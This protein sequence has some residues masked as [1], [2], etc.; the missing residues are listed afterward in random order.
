MRGTTSR[1]S[2]IEWYKSGGDILIFIS[3]WLLVALFHGQD[4]IIVK[5]S[6][7]YLF[8]IVPAVIL[9]ALRMRQTINALLFG[10]ARPIAAFGLIGLI[11]LIATGDW[12]AIPPLFLIAWVSGWACRDEI[13]IARRHL[14]LVAIGFFAAGAVTYFASY[15]LIDKS[16]PEYRWMSF[17]PSEVVAADSV[18]P[19]EKSGGKAAPTRILLPDQTRAGLNLNP[20]GV[21]P[22][23]TLQAFSSTWRVSATPAISTS[24][25]FSMLML[26]IYM[27]RPITRPVPVTATAGAAY[28]SI[29]SFVR[30]VITGFGLFVSTY[31]LLRLAPRT[32]WSRLSVVALTTVGLIV[33]VA[34]LS[35]LL[36]YHLQDNALVS[37]MFLR[38]QTGVPLSDIYRQMY[39]PW[40]WGQHVQEFVR[41]DYLMGAGSYL[42]ESAAEN[43]LNA[44]QIRS[45]S[46]SFLTRLLATYGL[47][48]FGM[49][50]FLIRQAY[51]HA[52]SNDLWAMA[53]L[54]TLV[55]LMLTW[56][57]SF[58]PTNGIYVLSFMVLGL[59]SKAFRD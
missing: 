6:A 4:A 56:G 31:I 52:T 18:A 34:F 21:L 40:L 12:S 24:A 16:A 2:S 25:L 38:G 20:W 8:A 5:W 28:F 11:W 57:S 27:Q 45:D 1:R 14:F 39:R 41:S 17:P 36:L 51:T 54:S 46:D 22:G 3:I 13:S 30:G 37:R 59:G 10:T 32:L 43:L 48:S 44:Y 55:W 26:L 49:L 58:H 23:Q 42:K 53:M 47:A 33:A 9:P 15:A 35:P 19:D 50:F 7:A 29:L